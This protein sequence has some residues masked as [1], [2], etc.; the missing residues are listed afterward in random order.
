L[1]SGRSGWRWLAALLIIHVHRHEQAYDDAQE[2]HD[3]G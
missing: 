3:D 2:E 1:A